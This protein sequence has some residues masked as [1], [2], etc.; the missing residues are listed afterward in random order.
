[1]KIQQ[2]DSP[3]QTSVLV[4]KTL[5]SIKKILLQHVA[6]KRTIFLQFE[7]YNIMYVCVV[8]RRF[9]YGTVKYLLDLISAPVS[10]RRIFGF[11]RS[12]PFN[13]VLTSK[14]KLN[15][16]VMYFLSL[17]AGL[18]D[19]NLASEPIHPEKLHYFH[20]YLPCP[21]GSSFIVCLST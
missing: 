8:F 9:V 12:L 15:R 17:S 6:S 10:E 16:S 7:S 21:I 4:T 5:D 14:G 13:F 19:N 1:M 2:A 20:M 3:I 18:A 11:P